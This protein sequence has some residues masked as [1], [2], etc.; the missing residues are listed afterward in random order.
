MQELN[1]FYRLSDKGNPKQ[2]LAN[3][4]KIACLENAVSVFGKSSIFLIADN[5]G[6]ETIRSI[7]SLGLDYVQTSLGNCGSFQFMVKRIMTNLDSD[8]CVYLLE[9]DYLHLPDSRAILLEGLE[10]ADYVSLYDHPDKY[11]KRAD[12]GNPLNRHELQ[13]TRVFITNTSH[14]REINSTTMTFACRAGT[15]VED[16]KIWERYA[17]GSGNPNDFFIF[18]TLSLFQKS[19][20]S[21]DRNERGTISNG[22]NRTIGDARIVESAKL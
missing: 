2:K 8:A 9:D 6:K 15:L 10:I 14:W 12:G 13:Q 22:K 18:L 5:C 3:A 17:K 19:L 16:F 1:V 11:V 4:G 7:E 20:L 21:N